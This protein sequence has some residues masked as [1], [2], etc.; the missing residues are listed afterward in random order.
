MNK[1]DVLLIL[2]PSP[3]PGLMRSFAYQGMPPLGIGYLGTYLKENGYSVRLLDMGRADVTINCL[4]KILDN[5]QIKMVGISTTTETYKSGLKIAEVVREKCQDTKIFMGGAHVTFEYEDALN[6]GIVD[7]VVRGE[8]EISTNNLC[9]CI[10]RNKGRLED[11][12][13]IVY[14]DKG[15]IHV[16]EMEKMICNLDNIPFPDRSLYEDLNT[17]AHPAT[18]ST[19]RG[20]PG[21]CVFCAASGLSGGKYRM[22]SPKNIVDEFEYLKGLGF[23]HVDIIDD[24]MTA[25]VRRL[26]EFMAE[27]RRR[28]LGMTW[29]CESR[30]DVMTKALLSEMRENGC[31]LIQFGVEAGSQEML[32][33]LRKNITISQIHNVFRWCKELGIEAST[34]LIIGQPYDTMDTISDTLKIAVELLNLG[35]YVNFT[36]CTPYPGT[37]MWDHLDEFGLDIIDTN[38]DHYTTFYPVYNSKNLSAREIRNAYYQAV[39]TIQKL[40]PHN[41]NPSAKKYVRRLSEIQMESR[42]GEE[43][44]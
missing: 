36:V 22:R 10:I 3:N 20:C 41:I 17:Y 29:Y 24:T 43:E 39:K 25:S 7:I 23:T 40:K 2:A 19:S 38:T 21:K 26:K 31:S 27:L 44:K 28:N 6:T 16:H 4:C 42:R 34:N 35:A 14:I 11:I 15:E 1:I 13:G 5:N 12:K 18:C 30:V 9:N 37:Y 32:D 33:C 8:G